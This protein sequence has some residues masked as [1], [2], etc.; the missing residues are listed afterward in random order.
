VAPAEPSPAPRRRGFLASGGWILLLAVGLVA[1]VMLTHVVTALRHRGRAVGDGRD[2]RTYGYALAPSRVAREAIVA[3]GMPK[4]GLPALIEPVAWSLAELDAAAARQRRSKLLVAD[5]AVI[6]VCLGGQA[7]A[8]PLRFLVWHEV[9]DDTLASEPILVAYHPLSGGAVV[10]RR[11]VD[12]VLAVSGLLLDSTHLLYGRN[13]RGLGE[14]LWSPLM[15]RAVTGPAAAAGAVLEP[16]PND[17][18]T[19]RAWRDR[20]PETTVLAPVGTL[21]EEYGRDPYAS[22]LGNDELRFPV[23]RELPAAWFPRKTE[24]LAVRLD[25]RWVALSFPAM[26]ALADANGLAS[27]EAGGRT[28]RVQVGLKPPTLV[29]EDGS[30][31]V[32]RAFAFAWY[33]LHP[34]D[35]LWVR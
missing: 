24:V 31:P 16:L 10:A 14:S 17:V 19:W 9:V 30:Q 15:L 2:P 26:V 23:R 29:L 25:G 12:T 7:R 3:A 22:Y 33:A 21:R 27:V 32:V 1:A 13:P 6:G 11:P 5:D 18:T 28:W 8:Y 34:H 35:T 20:H 4:D